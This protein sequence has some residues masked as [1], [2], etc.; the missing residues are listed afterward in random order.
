MNLLTA[1][2]VMRNTPRK[3]PLSWYLVEVVSIVLIAVVMVSFV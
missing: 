2:T 3:L 1:K